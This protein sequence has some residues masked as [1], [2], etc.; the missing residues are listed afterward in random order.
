MEIKREYPAT[1]IAAVGAIIRDGDRTALVRRAKEPSKDL[2][3]FPGGAIELGETAREAAQREVLEET[4][5]EVEVGEVAAVVDWLVR[6]GDGRVRYHY[7][8]IDYFARAVGGN[9]GPGGDVSEV[10]WVAAHELDRLDVTEKAKDLAR[11]LIG[12]RE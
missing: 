2:W 1:P 6:D 3:T 10:R 4:G 8:I 11:R 7:V 9:L 5:L 12:T